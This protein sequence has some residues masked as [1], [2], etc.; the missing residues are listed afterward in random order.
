[1]NTNELPPFQAFKSVHEYNITDIAAEACQHFKV[2]S[3][4]ENLLDAIIKKANLISSANCLD[5]IIK[6]LTNDDKIWSIWRLPWIY[7]SL[8][9]GRHIIKFRDN[10][11][12]SNDHMRWIKAYSE[13]ILSI[14]RITRNFDKWVQQII[15]FEFVFEDYYN[16]DSYIYS[17][18]FVQ[19]YELRGLDFFL[20]HH[21]G[22]ETVAHDDEVLFKHAEIIEKSLYKLGR[23]SEAKEL[24][25]KLVNRKAGLKNILR[26][27]QGPEYDP[28]RNIVDKIRIASER[29]WSEYLTP[30]VWNKLEPQSRIE[31][32][33]EFS[34]EYLLNQ[35]VLSTWSTPALALCKV[36]ERELA[37]A[38][39]VPWKTNILNASWKPP[40]AKS[41]K[42]EKRF[43][44]RQLTFKLIQSCASPQGNPPTLGQLYFMVKF[45][46][47]PVMNEC[48]N[49]FHSINKITASVSSVFIDKVNN[50][51]NVL[52]KPL[53][54]NGNEITITDARNRSAHPNED[55]SV[56]WTSFITQ[57]KKILGEPP[58]EVLKLVITLIDVANLAQSDSR[59][60]FSPSPHTTQCHSK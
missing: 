14:L 33:D 31:L 16:D 15:N 42:E 12:L 36:F 5:D 23:S 28:S 53:K 43:Q 58:A 17:S 41:K 52:E 20:F 50:C 30:N 35:Q 40:K 44:S 26:E 47:D 59:G 19:C 34:T 8:V 57:F 49:L 22:R 37:R 27:F 24:N 56:D 25:K 3:P 11:R 7:I 1:M 2:D 4:G 51:A 45:W 32:T 39:F 29:F 21:M 46:N 18:F 10:S 9:L 13:A 48:T 54:Q 60:F 55:M 6:E 38:I